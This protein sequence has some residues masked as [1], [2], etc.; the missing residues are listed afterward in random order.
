MINKYVPSAGA[1][2]KT[3]RIGEEQQHDLPKKLDTEF[4]IFKFFLAHEN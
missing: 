1:E 4:D 3:E 2:K